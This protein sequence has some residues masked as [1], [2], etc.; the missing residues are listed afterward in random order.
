MEP[1]RIKAE[2]Q[3]D[4]GPGDEEQ[5]NLNKHCL[6]RSLAPNSVPKAEK[7]TPLA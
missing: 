4:E 3:K 1:A 5:E 7:E 2:R 6:L